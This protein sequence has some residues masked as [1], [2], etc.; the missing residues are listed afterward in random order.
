[1]KPK[2]IVLPIVLLVLSWI[3]LRKC[4]FDSLPKEKLSIF[5]LII[6]ETYEND[7]Y[8]LYIENPVHCPNRFFISAKNPKISELLKGYNPLLLGAREDTTIIIKGKGDLKDEMDID[9]EIGDPNLEITSSKLEALPYPQGVSY[10]LLQGNNSTP[11]HNHAMSRYAFDFTMKIGDTITSSQDG[12]VIGLI[13]GYD[14]WGNSSKWKPYA[15][16][17]L[18]YDTLTHLYTMYGHIDKDGALVELGDYV[19]IGQPIAISGK[20]GQTSE[21]HLHFNVLKV[22]K[23]KGKL[24]SHPLDSIGN[25]KVDE[26]KRYQ[27]MKS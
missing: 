12:F 9:I 18:V 21:E 19:E 6:N 8:Q 3:V 1:M 11:T 4:S 14:G 7:T 15:N 23:E 2:K 24:V 26:L 10:E 5:Q 22:D 25:Y 16:Q 20:T 13:D 27:L 17:V